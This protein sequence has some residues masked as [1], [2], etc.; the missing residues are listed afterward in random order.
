M[1]V[2]KLL[3]F[4][5]FVFLYF[6]KISKFKG[7]LLTKKGPIS[8]FAENLDFL[9]EKRDLRDPKSEVGL[10]RDPGPLKRDPVGS[11]GTG[12]TCQVLYVLL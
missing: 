1:C 12:S 7:G 6:P 10:L 8:H 5:L 9:M 2:L 3:K 4:F 11:S